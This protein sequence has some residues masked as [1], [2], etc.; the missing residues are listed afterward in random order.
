MDDVVENKVVEF[1]IEDG[2]MIIKVDP[3]KDGEAVIS[4]SVNIAEIPDE[5]VSAFKKD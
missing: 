1:K 2:K 3:N 5:V 4:I